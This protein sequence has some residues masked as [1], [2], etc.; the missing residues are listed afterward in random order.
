VVEDEDDLAVAM[1]K[2]DMVVAMV[3]KAGTVVDMAVEDKVVGILV[4]DKDAAANLSTARAI[5][6]TSLA[7]R[8]LTVAQR[9][10]RKR[11]KSPNQTWPHW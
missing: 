1:T 6:V 8:S 2:V 4:E 11:K 3:I 7:T 9:R 10:Q 5:T